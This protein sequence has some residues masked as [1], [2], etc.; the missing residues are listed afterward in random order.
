MR[1]CKGGGEPEGGQGSGGVTG[2]A[3]TGGG[4]VGCSG[5]FQDLRWPGSG[6]VAMT[7]GPLP[8]RTWEA[9]SL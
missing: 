7:R 3:P 2:M 8:V 9:S 6:R 1:E 4:D 5:H